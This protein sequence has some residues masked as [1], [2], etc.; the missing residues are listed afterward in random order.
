MFVTVHTALS[1]S[2]YTNVTDAAF[3]YLHI[4]ISSEIGFNTIDCMDE[5]S[6]TSP[7]SL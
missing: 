3:M 7:I 6:M 4:R 2:T 5:V 1:A